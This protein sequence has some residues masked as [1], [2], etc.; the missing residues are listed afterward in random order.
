M[1]DGGERAARCPLAIYVV[2]VLDMSVDMTKLFCG[3]GTISNKTGRTTKI[4]VVLHLT[5]DETCDGVNFPVV[6]S[7]N[8]RAFVKIW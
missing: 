3:N 5:G 8:S 6:A 2:R 7:A 1:M 4:P